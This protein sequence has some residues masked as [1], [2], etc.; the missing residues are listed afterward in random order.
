[1][2]W[3]DLCPLRTQSAAVALVLQVCEPALP[4]GSYCLLPLPFLCFREIAQR[5]APGQRYLLPTTARIW[6]YKIW[7]SWLLFF[8]PLWFQNAHRFGWWMGR[9]QNEGWGP[10]IPGEFS[11]T[12]GAERTVAAYLQAEKEAQHRFCLSQVRALPTSLR[13]DFIYLLIYIYSFISHF[14]DFTHKHTR[15]IFLGMC[16]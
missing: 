14:I 1:M 3:I 10:S 2:S 4:S 8:F 6:G 9:F 13:A 5:K 15:F 11:W 12:P 7:F 16:K